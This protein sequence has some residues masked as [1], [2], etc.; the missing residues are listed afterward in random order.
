MGY[1]TVDG[2]MPDGSILWVIMHNVCER[3]MLHKDD[4]VTVEP[5]L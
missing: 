2:V 5:V 4:A 3:R 1:A